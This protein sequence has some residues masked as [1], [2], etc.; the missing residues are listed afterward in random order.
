[1]RPLPQV[2][3]SVHIHLLYAVC[4]CVCVCRY[5]FYYCLLLL[6]HTTAFICLAA[7]P[8]AQLLSTACPPGDAC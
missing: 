5:C 1:V 7:C 2:C 3:L 6:W 8:T 4:V